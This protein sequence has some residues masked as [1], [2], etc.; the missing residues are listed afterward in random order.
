[1]PNRAIR[2]RGTP[3]TTNS[4]MFRTIAHRAAPF[5]RA[6]E[7][8]AVPGTPSHRFSQTMIQSRL[9]F[10]RPRPLRSI[11]AGPHASQYARE[12]LV[13][14]VSRSVQLRGW[15]ARPIGRGPRSALI[16]FGGRNENV[17]W[18]TGIST[19]LKSTSVFCFAYRGRSGSGGR[20]GER[21]AVADAHAIYA[22]VR[23][24]EAN[25]LSSVAVM[26]RSL[27]TGVAIPLAAAVRPQHLVLVSPFD[28]LSRVI[29][30]TT[31]LRPLVPFLRH[32]FD[33]E[34]IAPGIQCPALVLLAENDDEIPHDHSIRLARLLGGPVRLQTVSATTHRSLVR[35]TVALRQVAAFL[36]G[37]C[38]KTTASGQS[39][40]AG[41]LDTT[42]HF[43]TALQAPR[44]GDASNAA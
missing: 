8:S 30:R 35:S 17:A 19:Y 21:H 4:S 16:Y 13:L 38:A 10:G 15:A 36:H 25:L 11:V 43:G 44:S 41:A 29:A 3:C 12:E 14:R 22:F 31:W 7:R 2:C 18:A 20:A 33:S 39:S 5:T 1:M 26:G 37:D 42:H 24:K 34:V 27:G 40:F 6:V 28:S 32:R 9:I 23:Q